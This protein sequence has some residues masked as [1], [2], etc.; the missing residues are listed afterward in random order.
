MCTRISTYWPTTCMVSMATLA[1]K[2]LP[3]ILCQITPLTATEGTT[4]LQTSHLA[5]ATTINTILLMLLHPE[6]CGKPSCHPSCHKAQHPVIVQ[7]FV[8]P[9][10]EF[11]MTREPPHALF[12]RVCE[13]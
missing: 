10:R 13:R 3:A 12:E 7:S 8:S 6:L 2:T 11:Q 5:L 1:Q 9:M 4:S